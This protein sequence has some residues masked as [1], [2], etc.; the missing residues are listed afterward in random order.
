MKSRVTSLFI[1]AILA[2]SVA[3]TPAGQRTKSGDTRPNNI[4]V[5]VGQSA[6]YQGITFTFDQSLAQTVTPQTIPASTTGKPSDIWPEHAG[7]TL[8]G[9]GRP[10]SLPENDPHIRVFSVAK[11]R[12]ALSIATK[13]Y[14]KS[15]VQPSKTEDW[16]TYLDTEVNLLTSLLKTRLKNANLRSFLAKQRGKNGC[17][18]TMPFL[19]LWESCQAF[20]ARPH[21]VK[22]KNGEGVLFLT[23]Q[24]VSETNQVT[25]GGLEYAFQGITNDGQSYVYA[26]FSVA[27]PF[28]PKGDEPAVKAW[29]EE[30][31]RLSHKSAEYQR[32]VGP[33]VAKL[34]ALPSNQF[35]PDLRL[36]EQL[37]ESLEVRTK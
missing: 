20:V 26:E 22:F 3:L 25:N 29:N 24:D 8:V 30:N 14:E 5:A 21:Y 1:T 6:T 7:F 9:L 4:L 17:G 23:Q 33:I 15:L 19:P 35:K 18:G 16:T 10:R 31:Y 27:A 36:L 32:Y 13:E 11:F 34:E 12:D 37:V 28:L 2:S